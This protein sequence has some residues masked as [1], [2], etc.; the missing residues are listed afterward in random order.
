VRT[1]AGERV[2]TAEPHALHARPSDVS[3][4]LCAVCRTAVDAHERPPL[5][6]SALDFGW[7]GRV[8]RGG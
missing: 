6:V 2:G 5:N 1:N 7:S 4:P 3:V 8:D